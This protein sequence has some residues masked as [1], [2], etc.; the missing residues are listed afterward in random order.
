MR[1][2]SNTV[3]S[4]PSGVPPKKSALTKASTNNGTTFANDFNRAKETLAPKKAP[5]TD[6]VAA[7]SSSVSSSAN[8]SSATT[9]V[10]DKNA[11]S[12]NSKDKVSTSSA[13]SSAVVAVTAQAVS[14]DSG[15]ALQ[16]DGEVSPADGL[17]VAVSTEDSELPV[18]AAP[19]G[20]QSAEINSPLISDFDGVPQER[21]EQNPLVDNAV[22]GGVG[23][24]SVA[25]TVTEEASKDVIVTGQVSA[26]PI[27]AEEAS[28]DAIASGLSSGVGVVGLDAIRRTVAT[29]AQNTNPT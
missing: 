17:L 4:L 25:P 2:D 13:D 24:V 19:S 3:L 9:K 1:T 22:V 28:K 7:P 10:L 15:K 12:T 11:A 5:A 14:Q 27:V 6:K 20:L 16:Q 23:L 21:I 18:T 8:S 29:E 26:A